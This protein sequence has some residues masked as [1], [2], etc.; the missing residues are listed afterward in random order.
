[1]DEL[2]EF[3]TICGEHNNKPFNKGVKDYLKSNN[4]TVLGIPSGL[5]D[6]KYLVTM[7]LYFS[8]DLNYDA[9]E[10]HGENI[11]CMICSNGGHAYFDNIP[12]IQNGESYYLLSLID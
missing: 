3:S 5:E 6:G 11:E 10:T 9:I 8:N 4:I 1:M 12:I 7:Y 2:E